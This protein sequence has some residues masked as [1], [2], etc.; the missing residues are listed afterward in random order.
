MFRDE[1]SLSAAK[2]KEIL[3]KEHEDRRAVREYEKKR[4]SAGAAFIE[5]NLDDSQEAIQSNKSADNLN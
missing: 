2:I 4:A 5:T 3:K 1:K